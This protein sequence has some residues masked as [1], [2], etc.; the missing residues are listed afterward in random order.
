MNQVSR[1]AGKTFAADRR[2]RGVVSRPDL[3][4]SAALLLLALLAPVVALRADEPYARSRDYHLQNA[5]I[6]LRFD[7]EQ[8]KVIGEVRHTLAALR[9]GLTRLAFDSV[10]L[11]V[12]S[13]TVGGRPA[14]FETTATQLL[15][16]LDHPAKPDEKGTLFRAARL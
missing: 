11:T 12:A 10:G 8:R 9:D 3:R 4:L 15:V 1:C 13:V 14:K 2:R 16:S 5:R 6:A 7:L